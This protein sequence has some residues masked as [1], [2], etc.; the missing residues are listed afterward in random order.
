MMRC[1]GRGFNLLQFLV[2]GDLTIQVA[3]YASCQTWLD[4]V[5]ATYQQRTGIC[6]HLDRCNLSDRFFIVTLLDYPNRR[7]FR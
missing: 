5:N 3:S 7:F 2:N 1:V 6:R 4:S